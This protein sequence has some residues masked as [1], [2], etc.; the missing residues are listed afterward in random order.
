[1]PRITPAHG[2]GN[3]FM[4]CFPSPN[5]FS[6][7]NSKIRKI[8]RHYETLP[9]APGLYLVLSL[10]KADVE[11]LNGSRDSIIFLVPFSHCIGDRS[12]FWWKITTKN[13]H[14]FRASEV[15]DSELSP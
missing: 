6:W 10:K 2:S 14:Q 3:S 13:R 9:S 11:K 7:P 12:D 5:E 4:T 8:L 15:V 1:M